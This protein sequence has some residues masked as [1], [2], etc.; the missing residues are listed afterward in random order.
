MEILIALIIQF[1]TLTGINVDNYDI[2][3]FD[4]ETQDY[5]RDFDSEL[6]E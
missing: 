6:E 5:I 4:Q 1:S 2:S 3:S